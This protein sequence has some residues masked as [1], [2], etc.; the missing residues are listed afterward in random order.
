MR[1]D[2]RLRIALP[3]G[4]IGLQLQPRRPKRLVIGRGRTD[5]SIY[6]GGDTFE[7]RSVAAHSVDTGRTDTLGL[8]LASSDE[9]PLFVGEILEA[10]ERRRS[11]HYIIMYLK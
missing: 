8:H 11:R 4:D 2:S 10:M 1:D 3:R 7:R 5:K 9:T 6:P